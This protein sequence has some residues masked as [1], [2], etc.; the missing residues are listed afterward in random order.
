MKVLVAQSCLTLCNPKD[1]PGSSVHGIFQARIPVWVTIP[2]SRGSSWPWDRSWVSCIA[3]KFFSIEATRE[4]GGKRKKKISQGSFGCNWKTS[5]HSS[6]RDK[7]GNLLV[8]ETGELRRKPSSRHVEVGGLQLSLELLDVSL[9]HSALLSSEI[10]WSQAGVVHVVA[11]EVLAVDSPTDWKP[12]ILSSL[13]WVTCPGARQCG[14]LITLAWGTRTAPNHPQWEWEKGK[15]RLII[16]LSQT[17][18]CKLIE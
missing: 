2:F 10:A 13:A 8:H 14:D 12:R 18:L 15:I 17:N 7:K 3:G 11:L 4:A 9:H 1:C 5:A 16:K 6:F